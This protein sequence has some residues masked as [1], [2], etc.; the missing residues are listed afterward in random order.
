MK[1]TRNNNKTLPR[2]SRM[3]SLHHT[4]SSRMH[5][6]HVFALCLFPLQ[7]SHSFVLL[8]LNYLSRLPSTAA[9]KN[10]SPHVVVKEFDHQP[11][12]DAPHPLRRSGS[13]GKI[14]GVC[15]NE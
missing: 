6:F 5:T 3:C 2:E 8:A 1:S 4:L 15:L 9:F 12:N 14:A 10:P 7:F 11:S 13:F